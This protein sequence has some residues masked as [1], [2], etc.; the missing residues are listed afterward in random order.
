MYRDANH[1]SMALWRSSTFAEAPE[2]VLHELVNM[3]GELCS[4]DSAGISMGTWRW[5]GVDCRGFL[6]M[7]T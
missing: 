5:D 2:S 6:W 3:A 7:F 1:E 4:A